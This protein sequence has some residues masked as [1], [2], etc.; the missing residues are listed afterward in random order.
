MKKHRSKFVLLM[1]ILMPVMMASVTSDEYIVLSWNDLGMHCANKNFATMCILPPYNNLKAQ[2]IKRGSATTMPQVITSGLTVSYEIPGNTYSVGK[3]NFWSYSQALFGVSTA[4][5]GLTGAGLTGNMAM[6]TN[7]YF[8]DGIPLTPYLDNNLVTESP[9]Q[10]ALVKVKDGSGNLLAQTQP[11]IP[12]SNEINCVSSGCHNSEQDI[13]NAH[14]LEG[15]FNPN[16]KPVKCASCHS[17]NA[18]GAPGVSGVPPFSQ[19]IHVKH[20]SITNDCY[21]CHPGPN[22]QCYRDVMHTGGMVCQDCHGS[23]TN[24]GQTIQNGRQPWLQEPSCGATSCHGS[25]YSPEAN[26]LYRQS[27]GHGNLYCS[28]CH[29][30]PHAILPTEQANDNVQNIA[31]QGWAGT[32]AKCSVCHGV[33]PTLPGPHGILATG[34]EEISGNIPALTHLNTVFPNPVSSIAHLGLEVKETG[35]IKVEVFSSTGQYIETIF[36]AKTTPGEYKIE[37]N[38]ENLANGVYTCRMQAGK[39]KDSKSFIVIR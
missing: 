39:L 23:V 10:L 14:E 38:T 24:V 1:I 28:A 9:F 25:N 36:S 22:T 18:L 16:N 8:Q 12:V 33:T 20:G 37:F 32:L 35:I 26:K 7:E 4:N 3:T 15:G 11:V 17:D 13:L 21:K 29:G 2:V 5:I 31:V 6:N 27:R 34:V 19:V 30:S